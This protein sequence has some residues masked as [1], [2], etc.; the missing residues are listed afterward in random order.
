M[1]AYC[2]HYFYAQR[3]PN[4]KHWWKAAWPLRSVGSGKRSFVQATGEGASTRADGGL[5]SRRFGA[6]TR[7]SGTSQT[8]QRAIGKVIVRDMG[9]HTHAIGTS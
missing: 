4:G 5:R 1:A 6:P 3:M 8:W 2:P 7:V 9:T